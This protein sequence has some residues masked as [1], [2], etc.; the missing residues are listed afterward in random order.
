[1]AVMVLLGKSQSTESIKLELAKQGFLQRL[2]DFDKNSITKSQQEQLKKFYNH[3]DFVPRTIEK[4]SQP[5][6]CICVWV[7]ALYEYT[8]V[9]RQVKPLQEKAEEL[10]KKL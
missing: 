6:K 1:M 5:C 4:A 7:L 9:Y 3:P 8:N 10:R 2:K